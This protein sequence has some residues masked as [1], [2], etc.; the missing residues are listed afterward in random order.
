MGPYGRTIFN[1]IS[2]ESTH[3]IHSPKSCIPQGRGGGFFKELRNFKFWILA[4]FL[5]FVLTWDHM[6]LNDSNDI[7]SGPFLLASSSCMS[8]LY[9]FLKCKGLNYDWPWIR[10]FK[11]TQCHISYCADSTYGLLLMIAI[12]IKT[13]SNYVFLLRA[14]AVIRVIVAW[15]SYLLSP[16]PP[17]THTHTR[18]Y[19]ETVFKIKIH[20]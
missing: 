2:S 17:H 13:Y 18:P 12:V 20:C 11:I 6:G 3:H 19:P 5:L 9:S 10:P 15:K 14:L 4:Q 8:Y 16:P 1:D 7:S